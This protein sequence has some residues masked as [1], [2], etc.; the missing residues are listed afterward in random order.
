M[1]GAGVFGHSAPLEAEVPGYPYLDNETI[2]L[3]RAI[4]QAVD[5]PVDEFEERYWGLELFETFAAGGGV[6]APIRYVIAFSGY[7]VAQT[8]VYLPA[9]RTGH[10]QALDGF[11]QRMLQPA[12]WEDWIEV[13]GGTNPLGPDNIMFS[14]HL[15]YMMTQYKMLFGD[16]K[17]ESPLALTVD[18][19]GTF[20]TDVHHLT[21]WLSEQAAGNL[22][23]AEN[24]Y[25]GIAC[26]PGH[27]FLPCNT[28]HRISQLIYDQ[29]YETD[30][31]Q[32]NQQWLEWSRANM[33][34]LGDGVLYDL[35]W[36]FGR[37]QLT[38]DGQPPE[39]EDRVSG[40]YN[41]WSIWFLFALDKEWAEELY[42]NFVDRFVVRGDQSPYPDGRT[43]VIDDTGGDGLVATAMD[44][45]ATGFGMSA[46]RTL[47]DME[48]AEELTDSWE[49]TFGRPQWNP[50]GTVFSHSNSPFPLLVGDA[51]AL[52]ARTSSPE[53]NIRT[54]ALQYWRPDRFQEPFVESVSNPGTF[55]NQAFYDT[56]SEQLIITVNGGE[57]TTEATDIIIANLLADS[58]SVVTRDG[59][60]YREVQRQNGRLI[61]TTP[62]LS[63]D[64]ESYIVEAGLPTS[65]VEV[66]ATE[67]VAEDVGIEPDVAELVD[68]T[69]PPTAS[70]PAT[71]T[72]DDESGCSLVSGGGAGGLGFCLVLI[73]VCGVI[74]LGACRA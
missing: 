51:Y 13:W 67:D 50:A 74:R 33:S 1:L 16:A 70:Q 26:E 17:Y 5:G 55:V 34:H 64:E 20:E 8:A 46:A 24:H 66:D 38:P 10:Q 15:V 68:A 30:Y 69:P 58:S 63:N 60:E 73:C 27:V 28:P 31:S 19:I 48:L 6:M 43:V 65:G 25:F 9:Y 40:I 47:D 22:D 7:A 11:I 36:P 18:G 29:L 45:L 2:G 53:L 59:E 54:N 21:E 42:P 35:Y 56:D 37:R 23:N 12:A 72:P 49:R 61:I 14:G 32:S 57:A 44:L 3:Y 4:V 41:G 62:A 71:D 39:L 52:L